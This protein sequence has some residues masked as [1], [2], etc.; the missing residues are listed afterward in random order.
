[1]RISLP[2]V[3]LQLGGMRDLVTWRPEHGTEILC[4]PLAGDGL[5]EPIR[6][7]V[8]PFFQ[9]HFAN[10]HGDGRVLTVEYVRYPDLGSFHQLGGGP[11]ARPGHLHRA[12]I[13]LAARTLVSEPI[14][15]V[16]MEFPRIHP[17]VAGAPHRH[18][19]AMEGSGGVV[20][21]DVATGRARRHA[22]PAEQRGGEPVFV[23]RPGAAGEADGWLL[24]L[25]G[26]TRRRHPRRAQPRR[27]LRH[28]APRG[29]P[30]ARA[31]LDQLIP[32]T[33]HGSFV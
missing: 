33:Y 13:D 26:D 16:A 24:Q 11:Q 14:C 8:E 22:L 19:W 12:T 27:R 25:V 4:I 31:W 5:G 17:R 30:V 2:H 23:P 10:A 18:V 32:M 15:D 21:V 20:H 28:A 6:F 7:T 9:W 1:M 3:F 29:R